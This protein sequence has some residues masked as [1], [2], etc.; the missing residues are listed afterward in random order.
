MA[1]AGSVLKRV[2]VGRQVA[3]SRMEHTL[4][5]KI[6]ALPVFSSDA[7]SSVAYA[8]EEILLVLVMASISARTLVLPIA[9]AIS[10]LMAIVVASYRQTV[11]AYPSGG[12]A[13][14]VSRQNLGVLPGLVAAA[15]LLTDYV[16]TVSVSV[17]AGVFAIT[18]A[19]PNLGHL[20]VPMSLG[21]VAFVTLAN[22]RG[23]RESG[24]IF[25]IPTYAFIVSIFVMVGTGLFR[26]IGE[27]P[28]AVTREAIG[29]GM[30]S[31]G[32][33]VVLHA[34][35]SGS[36]ALTGVEAISNGVPAFR[37]PQAK[38]AAETLAIMAVIAIAMFLGIS[39]LALHTG[40]LP[41]HEQ[42]LVS[43]IADSVFHGGFGFY[44]VQVTTAGILILAANTAYQDFPR[45][46]AILARDRFMPRQFENR[47]DRLVF[48]NGIIVLAVFAGLLIWAFDAEV[49]KLI[50]LYVVGVFTSFTLSQTGMVRHWLSERGSGWKRSIVINGV[51]AVATGVVLVVI[52]STK[53]IHGAW[54]VI[55][56]IPIIVWLLFALHRHYEHVHAQLHRGVVSI[57]DVGAN[58][59]VLVLTDVD[60]AA[61]EALGYIRSFRP[62]EVRTI[63]VGPR[64]AAEVQMLWDGLTRS[65]TR[66]E[67][68]EGRDRVDAVIDYIRRLPR[69]P[70][71]FITVVIP[72]LFQRRSLL[73]AIRRPVTFRLKV[74]LLTEP[75]VVVT[76]VPVL[77]ER[78]QLV[79][80]DARP[81]PP[82][83][84]SVLVF[85]SGV[86][87]ATIRALN[88]A[89]SLRGAETRAIY[90]ALDPEE[91]RDV[92]EQWIAAGINVQLDI[93]DA[94]FRDLAP[95][96]LEEVR[97]VTRDPEAIASVV[98]PE[99]VVSKWW[100]G[101]L[102]NQRALFIKRQLLFEPRVILSSVPYQLR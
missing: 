14:I 29:A 75:E 50:Q 69:E 77:S 79:G 66:I 37:R 70:G 21:F 80:V 88:Y 22:L 27:C 76:D 93:V 32:L 102:H 48:S 42:S 4:L 11:R 60:A 54:I 81:L 45:L 23:V 89:K 30:G 78:G 19:A 36:T 18:S 46:S 55:V 83:R 13:Y 1:T 53:F 17:A 26:C 99:F 87:D 47:G 57:G 51:G 61:S 24:T 10:A 41:S 39:Y 25:A 20:R 35:S 12:G 65:S 34:F 63:Y 85:I 90:V 38:N 6:L 94:P 52:A 64:R 15:A 98:L 100:R 49:S 91:A 44:A 71:G 33:F 82:E 96:V 101:L 9:I 95:P 86:H 28:Q 3:T 56:A 43:Q 68:P 16:L 74:R 97:R 7:L 5:P 59:V 40:A 8:T 72:E 2:L 62:A 92:P 73:H 31:I 67:F 58:R 84:T